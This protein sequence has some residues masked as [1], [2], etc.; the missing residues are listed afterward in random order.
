MTNYEI[1]LVLIDVDSESAH[2]A[3]NAAYD[4]AAGLLG[5]E[6]VDATAYARND[7]TRSFTGWKD[8]SEEPTEDFRRFS[9]D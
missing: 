7:E 2:Q 3:A 8:W 9:S 6:G 4:A 1:H 5:E